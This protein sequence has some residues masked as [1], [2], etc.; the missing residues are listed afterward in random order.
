M[1]ESDPSL[2]V[3]GAA[4]HGV[5]ALEMAVQAY[6]NIRA[7]VVVP[8]LQNPLGS[9]MPD[10]AKR[11]MVAFCEQH[12]IALI[13]D[14]TYSPLADS[15][16]PLKA[17]KAVLGH[18]GE[19]DFSAEQQRTIATIQARLGGGGAKAERAG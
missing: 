12:N 17:I 19:Y 7:V 6:D 3:V 9:I 18:D 8:N 11:R 2:K 10:A 15:N 14:D 1:I 16:T 13:E 5:E 4:H